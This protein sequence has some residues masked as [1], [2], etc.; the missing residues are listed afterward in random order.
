MQIETSKRAHTVGISDLHP[1]G[2]V[3]EVL[4]G[5][6]CSH[7]GAKCDFFSLLPISQ[8]LL[9]IETP[10]KAQTVGIAK[11]HLVLVSYNKYVVCVR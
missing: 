3:I 10:K 8:K 11:L 6:K 4:F 5:T 7:Q 9:Q 2:H 1:V